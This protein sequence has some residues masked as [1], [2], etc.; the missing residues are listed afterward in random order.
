M[1]DKL[2][3][4]SGRYQFQ[5]VRIESNAEIQADLAARR[6]G[7]IV[8]AHTGCLE[9]CR[10]L[11]QQNPLLQLNVFVHTRHSV[12][13]NQIL[14]RLNPKFLLNLIEVTQFNAVSALLLQAK[15]PN[16]FLAR[17]MHQFGC[18]SVMANAAAN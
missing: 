3:A 15:S 17:T 7:V 4:V 6:G 18:L 5:H 8:T 9:L 14:A 12:Q 1:L 10:A 11:A 13:F 2:L 16:T